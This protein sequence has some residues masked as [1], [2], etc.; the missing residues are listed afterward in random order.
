MTEGYPVTDENAVVESHDISPDGEWIVYNSNLRGNSDI[1]KMR[2]EGGS[3]LPITDSPLDE[4]SPQWSPDGTE[5]AFVRDAGASERTLMVADAN[6]GTPLQVASG[7]HSTSPSW[8]ADGLEI[9]FLT[10]PHGTE[11]WGIWIVSRETIGGPWG[12]PAHVTDFVGIYTDWAPDGSGVLYMEGVP[13]AHE[14]LLVSREGEV[15]WRYDLAS[16]GL[17]GFLQAEFSWDGSEIFFPGYDENGLGGIWAIPRQGGDARL[18]V[19][20]DAAELLPSL[21]FFS[22]GP[23]HLYYTVGQ[24]ESDIWV[25]DVEVERLGEVSTSVG[26]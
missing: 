25:M 9:T 21:P 13:L 20:W 6:G 23:D 1:Y 19:A 22:L 24:Y 7:V 11:H 17:W 5:I 18:V 4:F 14:M 10:S 3:P 15:L 2:L 16:N 12:E 8:S 26:A